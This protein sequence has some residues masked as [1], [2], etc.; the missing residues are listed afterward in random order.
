MLFDFYKSLK[1]F[2]CFNLLYLPF[3]L[4]FYSYL[5]AKVYLFKNKVFI[6]Q[7]PEFG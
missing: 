2:C 1:Y 6:E 4:F 7:L 3:N 5:S